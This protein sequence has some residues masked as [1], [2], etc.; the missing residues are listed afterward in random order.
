MATEESMHLAAQ[1]W[2]TPATSHAVMDADLAVAFA[3][4]L[5]RELARRREQVRVLTEA[6]EEVLPLA[7]I[8]AD[9]REFG[10]EQSAP[11]TRGRAALAAVKYAPKEEKA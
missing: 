5:D 7:E 10:T 2:C 8:F 3:E 6:L 4:T 1:A 9:E 11:I